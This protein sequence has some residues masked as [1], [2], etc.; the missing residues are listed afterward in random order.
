MVLTLDGYEFGCSG[1]SCWKSHSLNYSFLCN[2]HISISFGSENIY[3]EEGFEATDATY[4]LILILVL[5]AVQWKLFV[6]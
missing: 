1:Y 2:N 3:V 4:R 6:E 5:G